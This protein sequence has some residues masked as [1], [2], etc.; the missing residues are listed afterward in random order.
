MDSAVPGDLA[1]AVEGSWRLGETY[2]VQI[3]RSGSG[4]HV[5]QHAD[6][7]LKGRVSKDAD[8][9]Y[10]AQ[11]GA[12]VFGGIGS[13]HPSIVALR[14]VNGGLEYSVSSEV[15]PGQWMHSP[16]SVAQPG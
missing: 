16:W 10:D 9:E 7:R 15:S 6:V 11:S 1:A 13:I 2:Q 12:I 14:P 3:S 8:A 4:L 5:R